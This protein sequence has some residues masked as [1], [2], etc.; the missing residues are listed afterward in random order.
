MTESLATSA[1]AGVAYCSVRLARSGFTVRWA[2][3]LGAVLV[4][5]TYIRPTTLY[6]PPL[7]AAMVVLVGVRHRAVRPDSRRAAA[8]LLAVTL[9]LTGLWVWRNHQHFDTW[10]FSAIESV[11]L[12]WYH[13]AGLV[14]T[15]DG[16]PWDPDTRAAFTLRLDPTLDEGTVERYQAG[17]EVPPSFEGREG[18]YYALAR[19]E[20]LEILLDDPAGVARQRARGGYSLLMSTGWSSAA[21]TFGLDLPAPLMLLGIASNLLLLCLAAAGTVRS[22]RRPGL[23]SAHALVLLTAAYVLVVSSGYEAIAGHRFRSVVVPVLALYAAIGART[24]HQ[25]WRRRG[26][27]RPAAGA[28][29][30]DRE[31]TG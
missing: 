21:D 29:A 19:A 8:A 9:P 2:V 26:A 13:A 22:L 30:V 15:R 28:A 11:N 6:L 23:R 16:V 31:A 27:P 25:A 17:T 1:M 5:A 24:V 7:L 10:A 12:Y 4:T 20:A 3:A 14:A 18:E